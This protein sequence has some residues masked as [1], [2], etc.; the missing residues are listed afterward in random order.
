MRSDPGGAGCAL[1]GT[2]RAALPLRL[3]FAPYPDLT[4]Y[5]GEPPIFRVLP[6]TGEDAGGNRVSNARAVAKGL[7]FR[8][9]KDTCR[10]TLAWWKTLPKERTSKLK[11]GLS[12][13]REAAVLAAWH[14]AHEAQA[15]KTPKAG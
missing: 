14:E 3:R 12:P 2:S 7:T 15:K 4:F 10:D 6:P 11:A 13:E 9:L 8:P 5:F 1:Q